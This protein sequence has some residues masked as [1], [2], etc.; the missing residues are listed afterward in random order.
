MVFVHLLTLTTRP[1]HPNLVPTLARS[2]LETYQVG[3]LATEATFRSL[4][5]R[6]EGLAALLSEVEVELPVVA[7]GHLR[8]DELVA[9]ELNMKVA[10]R[11]F[12]R[13]D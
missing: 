11:H 9:L 13:T 1:L 12:D 10:F 4:Q 6:A 7:R 8:D 3:E 2:I 5:Q